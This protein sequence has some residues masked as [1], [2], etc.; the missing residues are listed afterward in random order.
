MSRLSTASFSSPAKGAMLYAPSSPR[1][2]MTVGASTS[3]T[4]A[5]RLIPA[6]LQTTGD[7]TR[8]LTGAE[9][10]AKSLVLETGGKPVP[11]AWTMRVAFD[12]PSG[13]TQTSAVASPERIVHTSTMASPERIVQKPLVFE[14]TGS[15]APAA[16]LSFEAVDRPVTYSRSPPALLISP[17]PGAQSMPVKGFGPSPVTEEV[18]RQQDQSSTARID[19]RMTSTTN[20]LVGFQ[21]VEQLG[22]VSGV[23]LCPHRI[24]SLAGISERSLAQWTQQCEEAKTV[25]LN[26]LLGSAASAGANAVVGVRFETTDP[27]PGVTR[28]MADGTAVVVRDIAGQPTRGISDLAGQ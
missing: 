5:T 27:L 6:A 18:A 19:T 11:A 17:R 9:L 8:L 1:M 25:A 26:R 28:F 4:S 2:Q 7:S 14:D 15:A 22:V 10:P 13:K 16:R 20:E 3:L 21:I 24:T 23:M 12:S